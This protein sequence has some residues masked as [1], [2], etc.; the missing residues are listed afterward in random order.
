MDKETMDAYWRQGKAEITSYQLTKSEDGKL[1]TGSV[2]MI[3]NIAYISKKYGNQLSEPKKHPGDAIEVLKCNMITE[4]I[5][6]IN[7]FDMMSSTYNP[8]DYERYPHCI[9]LTASSQDW[10]D[11]TFLQMQWKDYRYETHLYPPLVAKDDKAIILINTWLEDEIWNK[12]RL[13]PHQL[14]LGEIEIVPATLYMRLSHTLLKVHKAEGSIRELDN[15]FEY[16]INYPEFNRK[17][18]ISFE[19][20]F[21]YKILSWKETIDNKETFTAK[22]LKTIQSDYWNLTNNEDKSIRD[23]LRIH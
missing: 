12:I 9:K 2:V 1:D 23:S 15:S 22:A 18:S 21:P 16:S 7:E 8:V 4:F 6:G 13:T 19:K 14:P 5:S 3:F 10:S 17:I 20:V 11:Q